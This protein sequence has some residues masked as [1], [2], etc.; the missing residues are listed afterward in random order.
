MNTYIACSAIL[1]IVYFLL[2]FNVTFTRVKTNIGIGSGSDL[3]GPLNKAVRAHGNAAEYIP[4]FLILFIYLN[5]VDAASWVKWVVIA[6]TVSRLLH[7]IGMLMSSD[8]TKPHPLRAL[9]SI[10][11]YIGGLAL[12]IALAMHAAT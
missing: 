11:T 2:A 5:S 6:V 7:P 3:S 8:L 1:V 10:G 4:I 9:G 12:G